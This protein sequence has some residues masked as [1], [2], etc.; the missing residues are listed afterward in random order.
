VNVIDSSVALRWVLPELGAEGAEPYL[1]AEDSVGP[2]IVLVEVANVLGKKVRAGNMSAGDAT[3]ALQIVRD[4][5]ARLVASETLVS[6]TLE[7]SIV[8]SH[9]V[10]DCVFLTCAERL[11][12]TLVRR[13][14]LFAKRVRD[15]GM[16]HLLEMTVP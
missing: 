11:Q 13:D 2:D 7:L 10:Y 3:V 6:R 15:R 12:T 4:G 8:L 14:A 5:F 9:P 16:G 1:E